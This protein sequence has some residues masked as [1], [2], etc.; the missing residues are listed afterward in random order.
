MKKAFTLIELMIVIAVMAILMGLVFRLN[1][2]GTEA[3]ERTVTIL[4]LQKLENC[5]SGY[6]AAFGSYPPVKLHGSRDIYAAVNSHGVHNDESNEN[7]WNW[8]KIGD[9]NEQRAW[10]QVKAACKAQPVDCRFPY[11]DGYFVDKIKSISDEMKRRAQS[12]DDDYE[13]YFSNDDRKKRL[14]SGFDDGFSSNR[15]RHDK[16]LSDWRDVQVFKFGLMSYLLPRYLVMMENKSVNF[17]EFAQ[18]TDNNVM[19]CDPFTGSKFNTWD[20]VGRY[21]D[22]GNKG[23]TDYAR[24][25]NIPSQAVCARWMP[26]LAGICSVNRDKDTTGSGGV[27]TLFGVELSGGGTDLDV[28]NYDIEI[29]SPNGPNSDSMSGLYVLDGITVKDGWRNEFYY[30]SPS[31]YQRYVLWSAG[32][33]GR[34]FPPWVDRKT[35]N[36]RANEC[37]GKWVHDDI[38]HLSN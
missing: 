33:N 3:Q 25:A 38:I 29:Y 12:G 7:I 36:G 20:D 18:W 24:I 1:A 2:V 10:R 6:H 31:P 14:S 15:G 32:A 21:A 16:T 8:N 35:L 27:C 11:P 4:R 34:T 13:A 9:T 26:N 17:S 5:L 22:R 30:Y 19:P 28:D 37:V 23:N